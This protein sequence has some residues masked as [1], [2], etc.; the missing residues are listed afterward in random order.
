MLILEHLFSGQLWDM[1]KRFNAHVVDRDLALNMDGLSFS[2]LL[3]A[4]IILQMR[5]Q[6]LGLFPG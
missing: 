6:A 1:L 4:H 3:L 2:L 5:K